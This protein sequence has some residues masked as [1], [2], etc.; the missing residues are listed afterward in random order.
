LALGHVAELFADQVSAVQIVFGD[1]QVVELG[2][3]VRLD[4]SNLHPCQQGVLGIGR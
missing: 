3:L 4:Q 1:Q 2:T